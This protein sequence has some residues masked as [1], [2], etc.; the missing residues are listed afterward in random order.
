MS[1]A[2]LRMVY[3][4]QLMRLARVCNGVARTLKNIRTSKVKY[5]AQVSIFFLFNEGS[6]IGLANLPRGL[7]NLHIYNSLYNN[8]KDEINKIGMSQLERTSVYV[9]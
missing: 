5:L 9:F 7:Q 6:S 3:I 4:S 1:L 2:P 8:K